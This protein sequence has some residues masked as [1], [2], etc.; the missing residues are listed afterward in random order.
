MNRLVAVVV[1]F[2]IAGVVA[3]ILQRRRPDSPTQPTAYPVPT[4][5]DRAD[6]T[7]PDAPWLVVLFS[8]E[9]CGGC[10]QAFQSAIISGIASSSLALS[11]MRPI[12]NLASCRLYPNPL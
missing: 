1:V 8:S 5:L 11:S 10:A 6:F 2:A 12:P 3:L 9:T 7:R 4:Q